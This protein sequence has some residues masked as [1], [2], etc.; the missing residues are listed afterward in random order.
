MG[1]FKS[2]EEKTKEEWER[3]KKKWE[4]TPE[5]KFG[6]SFEEA[7]KLRKDFEKGLINA[8]N[9]QGLITDY[10]VI[11]VLFP[12]LT[13]EQKV[14]ILYYGRWTGDVNLQEKPL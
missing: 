3:I 13:P 12:G 1:L 8:V 4:K 2:R 9:E 14:L 10:S 7:S 5:C 6:L 11:N